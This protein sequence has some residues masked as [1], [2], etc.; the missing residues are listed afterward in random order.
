M[1]AGIFVRRSLNARVTLFTLTIFVIGICSLG[2]YASRML[3]EDMQ[4]VLGEQQLTTASFI[5]ADIGGQLEGRFK[6]LERIA[7]R[8]TPAMLERTASVQA[9]LEQQLSIEGMFNSGVIACGLDGTVIADVPRET[10]RVGVNYM[11]RDNIAAALKEGKSTMGRPN[12]GKKLRAPVFGITVPIRDPQ[13][14]VIGALTGVVNLGMP[15]FFDRIAAGR[16]GETGGYVLVDARHRL[17]VTASDKRRI[18]EPLSAPGVNPI[19]DRFS[20]GSEGSAVFVNALGVE[21]LASIKHVPTAGWYVGVTTPI[22]D[23]FAPIYD[24]Q[25]RVLLAT[26][27]LTL[28]AGGLIWWMLR[29]QLSPML[30]AVKTLAAYSDADRLAQ[31]LPVTR[32]DEIGRLI[33]GFNRLLQSIAQ[34]ELQLRESEERFR[35]LV[36]AV[37][38]YAIILL[39]TQGR[40]ASWNEGAKHINGYD[41]AEIVGQHFSRFH[42][43]EDIETHEPEAALK[44]AADNGRFEHSG[45]RVRKDG[46]RFWAN[47]IIA[48]V[49]DAAGNLRGFSEVTRDISERKQQEDLIREHNALLTRQ[50]AD[51]ETT[52]SRINR[53]EGLL[54]ICM[55]CKKIRAG[56]DDW[57]QLEKY[58]IEHSDAAFSHGFCPECLAGQMKE[59]N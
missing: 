17:I 37:A 36:N 32:E 12:M 47:V 2:F 46:S 14:K 39:D 52:L 48:P 18:M 55:S 57:Q 58:I 4:R 35:L 33:A 10:G 3:R 45:L 1:H 38:D 21:V 53:L 20:A 27:L 19:R 59:L 34:R 54:S 23:A 22:A 15:S 42:T 24:M 51:L 13:G 49:R 9:F 41:T 16:Y 8:I 26:I 5:A 25:R 44:A 50:K 30:S 7:A 40:V 11:E 56:E 6:N 43:R 29:R 28:I 31:P